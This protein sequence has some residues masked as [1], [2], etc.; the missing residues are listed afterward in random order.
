MDW[1]DDAIKNLLFFIIFSL[2]FIIIVVERKYLRQ[3][4]DQYPINFPP[5]RTTC[6]GKNKEGRNIID[7]NIIPE[8]KNNVNKIFFNILLKNYISSSSFCLFLIIWIL[9]FLINNSVALGLRL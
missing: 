1:W 3:K 6:C 5:N 2:P 9:E 4:L 8:K 7:I